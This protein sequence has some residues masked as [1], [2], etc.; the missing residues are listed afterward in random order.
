MRR[1]LRLALL[2]GAF[3]SLL[4]EAEAQVGVNYSDLSSSLTT[5]AS[6]CLRPGNYKA[7]ILQNIS[8]GNVGFCYRSA[9]GT[10]CTPAIGTKGTFTLAAGATYSWPLNNAPVNGL[11]CIHAS[12]GDV[13]VVAGR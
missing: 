10:A 3:S 1:L 13:S 12:S 11:D 8:S 2:A 5:A 4:T 7:V 9:P 6:N